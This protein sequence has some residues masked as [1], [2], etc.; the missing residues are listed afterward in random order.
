MS[1]DL[2][3]ACFVSDDSCHSILFYFLAI[4]GTQRQ[5][6]NCHSNYAR[7]NSFCFNITVRFVAAAAA[8]AVDWQRK[9]FSAP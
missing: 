3:A 5:A 8:A 4:F 9:V 6:G 7:F 1:F 2:I